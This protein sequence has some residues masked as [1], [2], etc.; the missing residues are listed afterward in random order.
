VVRVHLA[1]AAGGLASLATMIHE[2]LATV[3][4]A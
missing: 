4:A 2:T 3:P 1:D